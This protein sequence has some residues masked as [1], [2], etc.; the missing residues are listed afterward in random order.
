MIPVK[1]YFR[2]MLGSKSRDADECHIGSFI[3]GDW[4]MDMDLTGKLPDNWR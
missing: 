2:I 4:G 1:N 3:G